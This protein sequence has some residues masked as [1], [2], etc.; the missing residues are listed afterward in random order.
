MTEFNPFRCYGSEARSAFHNL[1]ALSAR[2]T[3]LRMASL[4]EDR[5]ARSESEMGRSILTDIRDS[6]FADAIG[7]DGLVK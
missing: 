5:L 4:A 7:F 2:D 6:H 1:G 3:A